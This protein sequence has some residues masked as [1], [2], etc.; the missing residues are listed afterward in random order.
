M[1]VRKRVDGRVPDELRPVSLVYNAYGYA[2]ASLLYTQGKTVVLVA[3]SLSQGVPLFLKGQRKGWLS[4]E[5]AMLPTATHQRVSRDA[6]LS[7]QKN[8]RNIE[9]SRLIGRCLRTALD[10]DILGER[11]IQIDCDVLQADGGTRV[12][13]I[14]AASLALGVAVERWLQRGLITKT[15]IKHSLLALSIGLVNGQ[16]CT[17]LCYEEDAIAAADFNFV[18]TAT[19]DFIEIQG[20]AEK[21][22]VSNVAFQEIKNAAELGLSQLHRVLES[23][24]LVKPAGPSLDKNIFLQADAPGVDKKADAQ[25]VQKSLSQNN[26]SRKPFFSLSSRLSKE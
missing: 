7:A 16:I 6:V 22:P 17:D 13:A 26:E 9:I 8:Y 14:T 2:D 21:E 24:A 19:G 3:V 25:F 18:M 1:T 15:L 11:T 20:T 12:A 10:L 23:M 4:A 5:Y